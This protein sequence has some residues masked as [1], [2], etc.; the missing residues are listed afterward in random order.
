MTGG[1]RDYLN[2]WDFY[3]VLGP[4][5]T[6]PKDKVIDLANDILSVIAHYSPTGAPPY[7][8]N[9]DRGYSP[10]PNPWNITGPDGVIDLA[11]DILGVINQ[12]LH[13]C[14]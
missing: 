9:F 6:L 12:Y 10:G 4:G 5:Q 3:D 1:L 2:P 7:D 13:N 8:V 14:N 11:N